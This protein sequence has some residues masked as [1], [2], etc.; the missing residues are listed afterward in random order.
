MADATSA[1]SRNTCKQ[2]KVAQAHRVVYETGHLCSWWAVATRA[3][4]SIVHIKLSM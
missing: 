3:Y 2:P 4:T 1:P